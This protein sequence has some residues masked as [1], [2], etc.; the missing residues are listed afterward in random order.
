MAYF[1]DLDLTL[2]EKT[3]AFVAQSNRPLPFQC[4]I[5]NDEPQLVENRFG[6]ASCMLQPDA[7]AVYDMIMGAEIMGNWELMDLGKDWFLKYFPEQYM[8]LL[9]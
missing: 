9:D 1:G 2:Q 4:V 5:F 3:E 7:I 6:G 8:I